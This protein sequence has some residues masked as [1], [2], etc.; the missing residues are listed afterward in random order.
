MANSVK[1]AGVRFNSSLT[2]TVAITKTGESEKGTIYFTTDGYIILNGTNFSGVKSVATG[3]ANGT[4]S[5]NGSDVAVKGLGS[6][7]Y[8]SAGSFATLDANGKVPASQLPSFVDDVI[9]GYLHNGKFYK[10][11]AHTTEITA[12]GGK[13][14]VDLST[15]KTYRYGGSAYAE[16]SA[17]LAIGTTAGTAYDGAAGAALKSKLDGIA[18]GATNVTESTVSGWGFTKNTGTYSKPSGGIP[19]SDL[20]SAV[21]TSLGK[22]DTALQSHQDISGKQDVISD[23]STIRS[24]AAAGATAVQPTAISD[25]ETKTHAS[26][27][28]QPKGN[29]LTAH[30]SLD[31]K[32][33][34][35]SDLADI[36]T[37][38]AAG[39]TA[40]AAVDALVWD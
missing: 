25:M 6:A 21:Q 20:A 33:D 5:V 39:V 12:E 16:I 22:A 34:V 36:R 38:A 28:Y 1:D 15:N 10:E 23:L 13:I 37:G 18:A 7:A 2:S 4:I 27:T 30:Q 24:G 9:E 14:Y 17:S 29:Y 31:S 8:E 35:I 3:S 40:L 26:Q 11:S 19:K 32:Q